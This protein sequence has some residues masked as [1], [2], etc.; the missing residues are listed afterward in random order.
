M[1]IPVAQEAVPSAGLAYSV[2]LNIVT[3]SLEITFS[4]PPRQFS[5]CN[6]RVVTS[7]EFLT[8]PIPPQLYDTTLR[9]GPGITVNANNQITDID[10][11]L[12]N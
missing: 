3:R 11:G 10:S 7:D 8:C 2:G 4:A 5:T 6:I 9:D 12:I 1:Q